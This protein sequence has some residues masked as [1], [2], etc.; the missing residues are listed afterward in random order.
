[1]ISPNPSDVQTSSWAA[2]NSQTIQSTVQQSSIY[3]GVW[4]NWSHG[5]V[6]GATL[7]LTQQNGTL[8]L[9]FITIFVTVTNTRFWSIFSYCLHQAYSTPK[10]QDALHNQR[11]AILRNAGSSESGFWMF[12]HLFWAWRKHGKK[13]VFKRIMLPLVLSLLSLTAFAVAGIFSSRVA[14]AV[15]SEVLV[16]GINCGTGSTTQGLS[17]ATESDLASANAYQINRLHSSYN[18]ALLCYGNSTF[19]ADCPTFVKESL[20]IEIT[21]D[22]SCPFPGQ[23]KICRNETGAIRVDSGYLDS[24]S[25]LGINAPPESRFK[26]RIVWDCAP[27]IHESYSLSTNGSDGSNTTD[28]DYPMVNFM[29]GNSSKYGNATYQYLAVTPIKTANGYAMRDYVIA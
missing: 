25:D 8:L 16:T 17:K 26:Y 18:Y 27:V 11:Q 28:A 6:Q 21:R 10:P 1:L 7:T 19:A 9:A 23:E 4:I 2:M 24:H 3:T 22:V 14:M 5:A 29:Y 13:T 12:L 15:G 20:P